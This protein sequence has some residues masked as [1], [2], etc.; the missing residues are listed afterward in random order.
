MYSSGGKEK[1][2]MIGS[3]NFGSALVRILGTHCWLPD[4]GRA[5]RHGAISPACG[6]YEAHGLPRRCS[7]PVALFWAHTAM[8]CDDPLAPDRHPRQPPPRLTLR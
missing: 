4:G 6:G 7:G 8:Q 5:L 2:A 3:G 1:I